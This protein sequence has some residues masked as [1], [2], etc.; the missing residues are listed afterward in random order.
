MADHLVLELDRVL[1]FTI[2]PD[3]DL[4]SVERSEA[5]LENVF[6]QRGDVP[7]HHHA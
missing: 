2:D 5:I 7:Q 3:E 1:K 4:G 6:G